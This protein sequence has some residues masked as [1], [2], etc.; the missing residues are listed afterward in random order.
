MCKTQTNIKFPFGMQLKRVKGQQFYVEKYKNKLNINS[1][2]LFL[3]KPNL[4]IP[5]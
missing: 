5:L 4:N 1:V 3:P 2:H